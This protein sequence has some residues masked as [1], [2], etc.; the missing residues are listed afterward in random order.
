MVIKHT[1]PLTTKL[2]YNNKPPMR[3]Q[4]DKVTIRKQQTYSHIRGVH[5][6]ISQKQNLMDYGSSA[7]K[8]P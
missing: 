1:Y 7:M 3:S 2:M 6:Y 8:N 4:H 5:K